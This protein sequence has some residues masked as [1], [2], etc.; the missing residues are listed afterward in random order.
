MGALLTGGALDVYTR[1][2]GPDAQ[3]YDKLKEALLRH[4]NFTEKWY[5]QRFRECKPEQG[6]TPDQLIERLQ[7]Y[8]RK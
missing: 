6:E 5:R 2:S 1:M 3:D 4:Y 8:L 7:T